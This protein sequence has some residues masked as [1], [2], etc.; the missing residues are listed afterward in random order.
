MQEIPKPTNIN[1]NELTATFNVICSKT[2]PNKEV[3][4]KP[5]KIKNPANCNTFCLP[6]R[7]YAQ[8]VKKRPTV[9]ITINTKNPIC[10]DLGTC[11]TD[12]K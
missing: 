12:S 5:A 3:I 4:K 10:K 2:P 11:N 6:K 7:S 1:P 8:L 9:I